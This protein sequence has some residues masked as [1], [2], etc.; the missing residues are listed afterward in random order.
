[1]SES[2]PSPDV[3]GALDILGKNATFEQKRALTDYCSSLMTT[4]GFN[5]HSINSHL[6]AYARALK[7]KAELDKPEKAK[8]TTTTTTTTRQRTPPTRRSTRTSRGQR[9]ATAASD[10]NSAQANG[11]NA[12]GESSPSVPDVNEK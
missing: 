9:G 2:P 10:A 12:K 4:R 6:E 5:Q 11:S 7:L 8:P 3:E 1:M